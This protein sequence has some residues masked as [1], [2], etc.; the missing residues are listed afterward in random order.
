MFG[1]E[2]L[3]GVISYGP[4][5]MLENVEQVKGFIA[6]LD[7]ATILNVIVQSPV[8]VSNKDFNA[9]M[10]VRQVRFGISIQKAY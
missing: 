3:R 9:M 7:G 8:E 5:I 6:A 10:D 4:E 2:V 1:I